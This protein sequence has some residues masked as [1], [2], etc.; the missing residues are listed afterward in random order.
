MTSW[1]YYRDEIDDA[2][3]NASDGKSFEYKTKI[4]RKTP[5]RPAR[6]ENEGDENSPPQPPA[7]SLKYTLKSLLH[8][9]IL[10]IIEDLLICHW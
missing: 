4:I 6:P 9:N 8:S 10:V 2:D 7:S 5:Q 3:D 1:N